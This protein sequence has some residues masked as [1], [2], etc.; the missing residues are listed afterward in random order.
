MKDA[1][2]L[3][4]YSPTE[5]AMLRP[6]KKLIW[7]YLGTH[8]L[9][10]LL[11]ILALLTEQAG[12]FIYTVIYLFLKCVY[13]VLS[14]VCMV[15]VCYTIIEAGGKLK[16]QTFSFLGL[17][18]GG[19]A[20]SSFVAVLL[21]NLDHY[22]TVYEFDYLLL[23]TLSDAMSDVFYVGTVT[24]ALTLILLGITRMP[25]SE[26]MEKRLSVVFGIGCFLYLF[27]SEIVSTILFFFED[28]AGIV[29]ANE[30]FYI[31]MLYAVYGLCGWLCG[32]LFQKML[33]KL[34]HIYN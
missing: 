28:S 32:W 4:A 27:A 7:G 33:H 29:Y 19:S 23:K 15:G 20:I 24:F 25:T 22:Y 17:L 26:K 30:V 13:P 16:K 21:N 14:L 31:L 12:L 8:F 2:F 10:G 34:R 6:T 18:W 9:L 1:F 5:N 11:H 3:K